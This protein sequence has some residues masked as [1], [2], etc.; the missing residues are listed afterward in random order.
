MLKTIILNHWKIAKGRQQLEKYLLMKTATVSGK[1]SDF[2]TF[3]L[4][5]SQAQVVKLSASLVGGGGLLKQSNTESKRNIERQ[6][7]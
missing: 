2:V 5:A 3:L 7:Q 1:F 4:V 6:R